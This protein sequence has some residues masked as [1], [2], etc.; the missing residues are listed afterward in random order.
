MPV[1]IADHHRRRVEMTYTLPGSAEQVWRAMATGPG[2]AAWFTPAAIEERVGGKLVFHFGPGADSTGE[3]TA[4]EP[5]NRFAYV[6]KGW[7]DDAPPLGT[8][9]VINPLA[10]GQCMVTMTHALTSETPAW[11]AQLED[12]ESGWPTFFEVLKLYLRHHAD[13]PAASFMATAPAV[14]S[15]PEA[16]WSTL[17][18]ALGLRHAKVGERRDLPDPPQ[19]LSGTVAALVHNDQLRTMTLQLDHPLPGALVVGTNDRGGSI[20]SSVTVFFYGEQAERVAAAS[21]EPWTAW[22]T[23]LNTT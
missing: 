14:A 1:K 3:V 6:E 9:I 23:Q 17:T 13:L 7:D 10:S 8:E 18:Q 4:W 21:R 5:P 11:D 19:P 22:L 20:I 12:F 16:A 2:Y 15:T